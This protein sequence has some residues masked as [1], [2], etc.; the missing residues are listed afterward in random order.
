MPKVSKESAE[1]VMDRGPAEDRH[2]DVEGY[3]INF[4]SIHE[5]VDLAPML[6]GLPDDRCQ[7]PHWGYVFKGRLTLTYADRVEVFEAGDAFYVPP[8]HTPIA[9]AHTEFVQFS[10]AETLR[11]VEATIMSN[12]QAM[13]QA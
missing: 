5:Q 13:Q 3:T 10:P 12:M 8:G 11:E 6:K 7:C 2:E 4:V 9:D 1:H